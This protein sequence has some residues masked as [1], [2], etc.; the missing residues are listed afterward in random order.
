MV[1]REGKKWESIKSD[2]VSF[3]CRGEELWLSRKCG[4]CWNILWCRASKPYCQQQ[5]LIDSDGHTS[6]NISQ[7]AALD[8]CV[9]S[10]PC[11]GVGSFILE[12]CTG[13]RSMSILSL[14]DSFPDLCSHGL[15]LLTRLFLD[16]DFLSCLFAC[17]FFLFR[18][19]PSFLLIEICECCF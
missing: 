10:K 1:F 13:Y 2:I 15:C 18:L 7:A 8:K 19:L 5:Q 6:F 12:P 17:F 16:L 3:M 14:H 4:C 11:Q 9:Y